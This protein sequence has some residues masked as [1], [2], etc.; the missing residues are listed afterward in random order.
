M[1]VIEKKAM[2]KIEQELQ[3]A[4]NNM[5][6]PSSISEQVQQ[7][8]KKAASHI[9]ELIE[10]ER[11]EARAICESSG[12]DTGE[13]AAAWDAV[14]ELQ[15]EASHQH[16]AVAQPKNSLERYCADNPSASECLIYDD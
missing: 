14:E 4:V 12:S 2:S 6:V 1:T 8:I 11:E 7:E 15:A 3:K 9:E 5:Q 13:C 16:A 10:R